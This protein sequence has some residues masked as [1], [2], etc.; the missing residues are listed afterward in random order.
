MGENGYAAFTLLAGLVAWG[1]LADFGIGY[2]LQNFISEQ[3]ANKKQY[4][5]YI[6]T[7]ACLI[8]IG[9]LVLASILW[10]ITKFLAPVYLQGFDNN[11]IYDKH[12]LL[13]ITLC[14]FIFT[15]FGGVLYK[16][17]FAEQRGWIANV[18]TALASL[19][20]L[21]LIVIFSKYSASSSIYLAIIM[22]FGPA[23]LIPVTIFISRIIKTFRAEA[24]DD[25]D[26]DLVK[27]ILKRSSG[28]LFFAFLA[29]IVLQADYIVMSQKLVASDIIVYTVLIKIFGLIL[30]VYSALLQALWPVC[31]EY[32]VQNKWSELNLIVNKYIM[33]G[34]IFI[35][36]CSVGFYLFKTQI[37]GLISKKINPNIDVTT[38]AL[39]GVYFL[40]RIWTDTYAMLLQSMNYLRPLWYLVPVQ[41]ILS[42][43]LQ[44]TLAS[45]YGMKGMLTGL[46]LSFLFTVVIF[47]PV[48]YKRKIKE[49]QSV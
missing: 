29:T 34:A 28:F 35:V 42:L 37:I 33:L 5:D 39:F 18:I 32:R 47:L 3:R 23:A 31:A 25:F 13:Y 46:I 44:W 49:L 30:F 14:I 8:S 15:S 21:I 24:T 20:G 36:I 2:S 10:P 7:S 17:L 4:N 9:I 27:I 6:L 12:L 38:I 26:H 48:F 22:F 43:S 41:A 40:L 16:I 1:A 11:T 45:V 19:L